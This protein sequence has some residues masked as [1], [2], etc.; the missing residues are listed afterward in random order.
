[1]ADDTGECQPFFGRRPPVI[2]PALEIRVKLNGQ[3]LFKQGQAVFN[4]SPVTG[5]D[6]DE[7]PDAFRELARETEGDQAAHRG[8]HKMNAFYAQAVQQKG[9]EACLVC[10]LHVREAGAVGLA[11]RRAGGSGACG[12]VAASQVIGADDAEAVCVQRLAGADDAVPPAL[13]VFRFPEGTDARDFRIVTVG[14][15]AA[16]K[17]MEQQ[18]GVVFIRRQGSVLFVGDANLVQRSSISQGEGVGKIQEFG[19]DGRKLHGCTERGL[20]SKKRPAP[21]GRRSS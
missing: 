4:G 11:V 19:L 13:V 3:D 5:A 20:L 16:G 8:A 18:D 21:G 1:M 6:G 15:L 17:S 10:D 12:A 7:A 2:I 14:V 9:L